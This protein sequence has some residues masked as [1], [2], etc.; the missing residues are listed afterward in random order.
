MKDL[1][2]NVIGLA[3]WIII[4][5]GLFLSGCVFCLCKKTLSYE[6]FTTKDTAK[7]KVYNYWA[8]WCGW[9]NKFK[10]EWDKFEASCNNDVNKK[11]WAIGVQ[12]DKGDVNKAKCEAAKVPGFPSI[13]FEYKKGGKDVKI[14]YEGERTKDG[15]NKKLDELLLVAD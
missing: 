3:I 15:I 10:P 7:V 13:R 8:G 5:I 1:L 4:I 6:K 9:S 2:G 14:D 12:C 11:G